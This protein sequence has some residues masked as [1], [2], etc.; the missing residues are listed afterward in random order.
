MSPDDEDPPESP[1][2]EEAGAGAGVLDS[3][4]VL[5]AGV[6]LP[7]PLDGVSVPLG[8]ELVDDLADVLL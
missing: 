8:L 7:L 5:A 4:V 3:P 1:E 2:E 6:S